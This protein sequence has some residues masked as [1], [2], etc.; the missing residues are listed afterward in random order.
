MKK[1][2]L[3]TLLFLVTVIGTQAQCYEPNLRKADAAYARGSWSSAYEYY[4]RATKCP[5]ATRFE[6]G[7]AAKAGMQKCLPVLKIDGKTDLNITV[8]TEAGE[9]TFNVTSSR[10]D[11][12]GWR[13]GSKLNCEVAKEDHQNNTITIRWKENKFVDEKKI[14]FYI[15]GYGVNYVSTNVEITQQGW[16]DKTVSLPPGEKYDTVII[17]TSGISF[18]LYHGKCGFIDSAGNEI[19]PLKYSI[20]KEISKYDDGDTKERWGKYD[21][22]VRVYCNGK[23][24]YIN[25]EGREVVPLQ[26][27]YIGKASMRY[28]ISTTS[29]RKNGKYGLLGGS[30]KEIVP[31]IYDGFRGD[32]YHSDDIQPIAFKKNGKWALFDRTGEQLTNFIYDSI[33]DFGFPTLNSYPLFCHVIEKGKHGYLNY[34]GDVVITPKYENALSFHNNRAFVQINGECG[35]INKNGE[36]VI[37]CIYKWSGW[38]GFDDGIAWVLDNEGHKQI[39]TNGVV[40]SPICYM[41]ILSHSWSQGRSYYKVRNNKGTV[42]VGNYGK[43]YMTE[44]EYTDDTDG[45]LEAAR[46]GSIGEQKLLYKTLLSEKDSVK[47]FE[48]C[49]QAAQSMSPEIWTDL[50]KKYYYGIGVKKNNNEAFKWFEKAANAY[51]GEALR[52]LGWMFWNGQGCTTDRNK[53][54]EMEHKSILAGNIQAND[55]M[56]KLRMDLKGIKPY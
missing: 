44:K 47:S 30:G 22:L 31:C 2:F 26:Y 28:G 33:V 34:K 50:A 15:S 54:L 39:D 35:Y 27:D 46:K 1:T 29:I 45:M 23:Y 36:V 51:N 53:A 52:Y 40:I 25:R 20:T 16:P 13:I 41:Q 14:S 17:G 10:L 12:D 18:V 5:D 56:K 21:M 8:G 6:N 3:F 48:L 24:G 4:K 49:Y 32:S 9:R 37:P 19:A 55:D 11:S 43:S 7:K 42:Y 38:S